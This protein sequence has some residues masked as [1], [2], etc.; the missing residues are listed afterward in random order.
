LSADSLIVFDVDEL[1]LIDSVGVKTGRRIDFFSVAID[2]CCRGLV[3]GAD[4]IPIEPIDT[5]VLV[6]TSSN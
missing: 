2:G 1:L 3:E 6:V 5:P 4:D